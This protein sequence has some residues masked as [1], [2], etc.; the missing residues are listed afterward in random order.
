MMREQHT[1]LTIQVFAS[2]PSDHGA[3]RPVDA[4]R[5]VASL[6]VLSAASL[7]SQ[8]GGDIDRGVSDVLAWFPGF[9][10]SCGSA[11]CGSPS[12]GRWRCSSS[13]D[14]DNVYISR[15]RESARL[16]WH[17]V[18]FCLQPRSCRGTRVTCF[19]ESPIPMA[20]RFSARLLGNDERSDRRVR[21]VS[22]VAVSAFSAVLW[23]PPRCSVRS[24]SASH[25]RWVRS[26][27]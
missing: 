6:L 10:M 9:S 22:D 5:A 8:I 3:Q 12:A 1:W 15:S 25:R 18:S 7:L 19:D 13:R 17:W 27:H 21:S 2:S 11:G 20:H 23:W 16:Y 14:S 24:F 26:H 4:L